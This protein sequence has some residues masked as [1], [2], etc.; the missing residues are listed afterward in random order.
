MKIKRRLLGK[1]ER[2]RWKDGVGWYMKGQQI[3]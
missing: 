3:G 1:K 2:V